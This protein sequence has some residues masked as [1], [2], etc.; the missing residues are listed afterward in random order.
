MIGNKSFITIKNNFTKSKYS[1]FT[2]YMDI[3]NYF[4][5]SETFSIAHRTII[6]RSTGHNPELFDLYG[7]NGG[8]GLDYD[9]DYVNKQYYDGNTK[10]LESLELRYPFVDYLKLGFPLPIV[11]GDIRGSLFTDF[12]SVWNWGDPYRGSENGRLKDLKFGFGFGP[13]MNIGYFVIK[14]DVAWSSNFIEHG[15]PSYYFSIN[16]DF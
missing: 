10:I 15:K 4:P 12:G 16:E 7:F 6:G 13:R 9:N 2:A 5:L 14:L 1:Y 8:R 11:I 3:R